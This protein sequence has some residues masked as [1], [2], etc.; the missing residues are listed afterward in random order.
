MKF[1]EKLKNGLKKTKDA[2]FGEFD[3]IAKCFVKVDDELLEELE[4]LLIY[5]DVGVESSEQI[6]EELRERVLDGRLKEPPQVTEAL[7]EISTWSVFNNSSDVWM[8]ALSVSTSFAPV[9]VAMV[10]LSRT[11]A[12]ASP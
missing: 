6:I 3:N 8:C 1:F 2:I 4:E 12:R 9:L 10:I 11:S 5:A 7:R